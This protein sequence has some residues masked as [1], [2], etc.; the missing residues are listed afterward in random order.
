MTLTATPFGQLP[1][2]QDGDFILSQ[3]IVIL[4]YLAN[5]HGYGG[6]NEQEVAKI[7]ETLAAISDLSAGSVWP[8]IYANFSRTVL[9]AMFI[10]RLQFF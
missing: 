8:V 1:V 3:S 4:K 10:T 7:D 6:A 9:M 5:K 2:L